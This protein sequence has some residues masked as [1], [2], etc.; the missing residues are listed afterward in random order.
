M[1]GNPGWFEHILSNIVDSVVL[2]ELLM[3]IDFLVAALRPLN[4]P[5]F[6]V[7]MHD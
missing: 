5:T 4:K 2:M 3:F 6:P 1:V 7:L